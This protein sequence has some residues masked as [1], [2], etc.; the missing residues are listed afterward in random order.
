[1]PVVSLLVSRRQLT[2]IQKGKS[3]RLSATQLAMSDPKSTHEVQIDVSPSTLKKIE[4]AKRRNKGVQVTGSAISGGKIDFMNMLGQAAEFGKKVVGPK[5]LKAGAKLAL[6]QTG[7]SNSLT[8]SLVDNSVDGLMKSDLRTSKGWKGAARRAAVNTGEDALNTGLQMAANQLASN[9]IGGSG[10]RAKG[11]EA[12]R[13]HMA[14]LR[15]M[16]KSA[17]IPNLSSS[18]EYTGGRVKRMAASIEQVAKQQQ[19][20]PDDVSGHFL[21]RQHIRGKGLVPI[22]TGFVPIG[23]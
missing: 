7:I 10:I 22:G 5:L 18:T 14:K 16:R 8:D 12:A 15:A 11:S 20:S 13:N 3:I 1:M 4:S 21:K 6:S 9:Q 23:K 2:S 17:S 19:F